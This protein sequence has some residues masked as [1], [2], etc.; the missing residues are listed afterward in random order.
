LVSTL[1]VDAGEA[2]RGSRSHVKEPGKKTN[3]ESQLA[4]AA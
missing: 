4:L 1:V 3:A 2:S